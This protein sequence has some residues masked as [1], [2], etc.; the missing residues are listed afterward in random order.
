MDTAHILPREFLVSRWLPENA[1]CLCFRH[2][3]VRGM[4]WHSSILHAYRF[5]ENYLG[6][7]H[8][9]KL[10]KLYEENKDIQLTEEWYN[11][12]LKQFDKKN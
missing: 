10:L 3:K 11:Q 2:H 1:I 12:L 6:K 8:I 9:D 5:I 4:S 7:D